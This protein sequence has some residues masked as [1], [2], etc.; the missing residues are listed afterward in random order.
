MPHRKARRWTAARNDTSLVSYGSLRVAGRGRFSY[1]WRP[2]AVSR[3]ASS[4]SPMP[5]S[6]ATDCPG[7]CFTSAMPSTMRRSVSSSRRLSGAFRLLSAI[8]SLPRAKASAA[9][10]PLARLPL[11][12]NSS[13]VASGDALCLLASSLPR[14]PIHLLHDDRVKPLCRG[15]EAASGS[16]EGLWAGCNL[17][18]RTCDD[19]M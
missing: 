11:N 19:L 17:G 16:K 13:V 1:L 15:S 7:N 14:H 2:A 4:I 12:S 9:T 6:R 8:P 10:A 3:L 5:L 18:V